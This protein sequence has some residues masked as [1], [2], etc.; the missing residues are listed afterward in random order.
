VTPSAPSPAASSDLSYFPT[1]R[2]SD[3]LDTSL[4]TPVDAKIVTDQEAETWIFIGKNVTKREKR[5]FVKKSYVKLIQLET[6]E[7]HATEVLRKLGEEDITSLFVEGG[8]EVNGSFLESRRI[9]QVVTYLAPK[10]I[11]GKTAPTSFSG[12]GFSKM[13]DV[14]DVEIKHVEKIGND[15]KIVAEPREEKAHV[16]GNH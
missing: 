16:Y 14:L 5:R 10:L 3:L 8:A 2:S 9:N 4:R 1:R 15:I 13:E 6:E 12:K 11:G 7:I